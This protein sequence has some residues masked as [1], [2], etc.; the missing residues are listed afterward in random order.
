MIKMTIWMIVNDNG[1]CDIVPIEQVDG[2][3]N[4]G[5]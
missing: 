5:L 2:S 4:N 1:S 3:Q